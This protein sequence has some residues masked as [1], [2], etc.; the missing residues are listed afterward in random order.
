MHFP[1]CSTVKKSLPIFL[2]GGEEG[3]LFIHG[4][5]GSPHDFEY[6]AKELNREGFTVSVPRLPGHGTCGE[7][8]LL[9]GARD[10]LRRAFD[11]YYD[12]KAICKEVHVV[13]LSM[14]G[15]I[16]IILAARM[17]PRKLVTLAA[18]THVFDRRIALTPILKPFTKKM[19]RENLETYDDSDLEYLRKEYWSYNWPKQAAELYKLMKLSRKVVKEVTSEIL[20]VAAKN[21]NVVPM[22]AAEFIYNSVR[23]EKRKLLVFEKSGHVLSND[24]EKE[25]V[26]K[27]VIDW[28]KGE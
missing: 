13:G 5:T 4:Y 21:D 14:G 20:V 27:A 24:V 23:S 18:A 12:M 9:S 16:A 10:W 19:P 25:D 17:K 22:R 11:A 1:K 7:D 26:T 6:M 15:V 2:E 8:F 28:L 3:V